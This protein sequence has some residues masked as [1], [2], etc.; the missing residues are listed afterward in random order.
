MVERL[1]FFQ[2]E[3]KQMGTNLI[4]FIQALFASEPFSPEEIDSLLSMTQE[5]I[6]K[7]NEYV[8]EPGQE[9]TLVRFVEKGLFRSF[10]VDAKGEEHVKAFSSESQILPPGAEVI[11][12]NTS[13]VCVQAIEPSFVRS[14]EYSRLEQFLR[15]TGHLTKA[16]EVSLKFE[17][18]RADRRENDFLERD[19]KERYR[20]FLVD[21]AHLK[22]RVKQYDVA[23]YLGISHVS[24]SRIKSAMSV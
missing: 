18:I 4:P 3:E 8:L 14:I 24:L 17:S 20:R 9:S 6:V 15:E 2:I 21:N 22:G 11:F 16:F 7:A 23:S 1:E 13:S 5:Q 10:Y 19:A 12:F